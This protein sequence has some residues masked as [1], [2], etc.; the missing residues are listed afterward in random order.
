MNGATPPPVPFAAQRRIEELERQLLV[1]TRELESSR[2]LYA[3]REEQLHAL[4][5]QRDALLEGLLPFAEIGRALGGRD[6]EDAL[7]IAQ[8]S[9]RAVDVRLARVL[10]F[11]H[12]AT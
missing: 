12:E 1:A 10:V 8:A 5:E 6:S 9:V 7:R 4:T 2:R 11:P 3:M